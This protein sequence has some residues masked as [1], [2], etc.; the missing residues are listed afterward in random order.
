MDKYLSAYQNVIRMITDRRYQMS[1]GSSDLSSLKKSFPE[2]SEAFKEISNGDLD[3]KDLVDPR[4]G[5]KVYVM[6][7]DPAENIANSTTADDFKRMLEPVIEHYEVECASTSNRTNINNLAQEVKVIVVY[8]GYA[9]EKDG[10]YKNLS[11]DG[12]E[13][14][15]I[16]KI[17]SCFLDNVIM[18][19]RVIWMQKGSDEYNKIIEKRDVGMSRIN[20]NDPITMWFDARVGD[21]FQMERRDSSI[22]WRRVHSTRT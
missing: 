21:I 15:P 18:P 7:I 8:M 22:K 4:S 5:R 9:N 1:D 17:T 16:Q 2:F 12:I 11:R 13:T 20:I 14:I 19:K 6:F 3:I 10:K